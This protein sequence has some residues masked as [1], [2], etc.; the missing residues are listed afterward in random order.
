MSLFSIFPH[1]HKICTSL[2]NFS[3]LGTDTI[4]LIKINK[5]K[6]DWQG[7]Y[8]FPNLRRIPS[9]YTLYS[10]HFYDNTTANL[11][12]PFSPPHNIYA[13]TST[14]DEMLFDAIQFMVYQPGN[15]FIDVAFLLEHDP[16]FTGVDE[17]VDA[18]GF[19]TYIYPNPASDKVNIYLTKKS[20]YKINLFDVTG[21]NVLE[22]MVTS[23]SATLDVSAFAKGLY[24]IQITDTRSNE[25]ITRKLVK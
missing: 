2:V 15:E 7:Y 4:P 6:F 24:L 1:S 20:E 18:K 12:N 25:V 11:N 21:Q 17:Q 14:T 5:W 3:A 23:D 8:T 19:Q 16:L 10:S 13:G 9:T 22:I